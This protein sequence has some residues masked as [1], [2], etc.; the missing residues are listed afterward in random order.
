[1]RCLLAGASSEDISRHFWRKEPTVNA[2][3]RSILAKMGVLSQ[4]HLGYVAAKMG[5]EP[6]PTV[7]VTRKPFTGP[8]PWSGRER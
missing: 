1:M 8:E 2:Q 5:I 3:R 6:D 4:V 7:V